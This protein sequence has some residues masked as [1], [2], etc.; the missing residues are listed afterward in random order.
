MPLAVF[1]SSS[2]CFF[3]GFVFIRM[4]GLHR[5]L[6][7]RIH[8]VEHLRASAQFCRLGRFS[9]QVSTYRV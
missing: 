2:Q 7:K 9:N 1:T 5:S 8:V 4:L 3:W 6:S